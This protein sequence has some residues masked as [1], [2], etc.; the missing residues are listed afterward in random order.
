MPTSDDYR[1]LAAECLELAPKIS[2]DLRA[3]FIALAQGWAKLADYLE[4]DHSI[5]LDCPPTGEGEDLNCGTDDGGEDCKVR[6]RPAG[7]A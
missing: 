5:L 6:S 1:R 3:T 7:I 4:E 2:P